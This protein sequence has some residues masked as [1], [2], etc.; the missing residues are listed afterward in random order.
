MNKLAKFLRALE[1]Y[2]ITDGE[3]FTLAQHNP[4]DDGGLGLSKEDGAH[5]L[6]EVKEQ[7]QDLQELLYANQTRSVL[8]I[9]QGMDAAGKD[10]TIK[11][12]MSGVNPQGVTVASF[13]QPGPTELQH[14]FLWRIHAAAP[15]VGRIV[16]F[17]RSQYEDVL[18]TRVHPE[19]LENEHLT[20]PVNTPGF[21]EG[22]YKDIR[23]LEHYLARQGTVVLKFFLNI[24]R[25]EQRER[26]LS[27]LEVPEKRW[28]FSSSDLPER[29]Y[30][31]HYPTY[32]QYALAATARTYAP[33]V[34]VPANHKWY[35]RL[36]VTGTIIRALRNL[37]Q[38]PPQP[39]P[40][41]E[42]CLDDYRTHLLN[43]KS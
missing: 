13:K 9:L 29:E 35:A 3:K 33:W 18:V 11:H 27:R 7:L 20:G 30:W 1:S 14:G 6:R 28:N 26:L 39:A 42:K 8:I 32:Y 2:H 4:D 25:K 31:D 34:I 40:D 21:W 16:I 43:E 37:Q 23:H 15:Q 5:L 19:L 38:K 24:S 22:R 10:G 36:V 12:V 17:N 41:V